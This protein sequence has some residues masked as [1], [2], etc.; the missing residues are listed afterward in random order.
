MS[1]D[2]ESSNASS[3]AAVVTFNSKTVARLFAEHFDRPDTRVSA[4]AVET[5][6]EYLRIFTREAIWRT[7]KALK[8]TITAAESGEGK[9]MAKISGARARMMGGEDLERIA[10]TLVLDF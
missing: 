1:S 5:S 4:S 8:D 2:S 10:G 7:D 3:D 6:A 9:Q